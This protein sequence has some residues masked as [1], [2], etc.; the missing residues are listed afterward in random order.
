MRQ[1]VMLAMAFALR[2]EILIADEPT[3]ALDMT[4]QAQILNLMDDLKAEVGASVL[5]ITHDMG[6]VAQRADR[7]AVMYAG[8]IMEMAGTADL[9]RAPRHPYTQALLAS[10]PDPS[11]SGS[12][13]PLPFLDGQPPRIDARLPPMC[14]FAPRCAKQFDACLHTEPFLEPRS[15]ASQPVRC[16]LYEGATQV[17]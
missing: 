7:V 1:R 14:A 17:Q 15:N 13:G 5:L 4:V 8:Q 12:S 10:I 11:R 3:T 2:P 16:L 6:I 9:F